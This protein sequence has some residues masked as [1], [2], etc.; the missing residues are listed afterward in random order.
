[1]YIHVYM[2][3]YVYIYIYMTRG[4][5]WDFIHVMVIHYMGIHGDAIR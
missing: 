3:K 4:S 1:M 2:Y 5:K